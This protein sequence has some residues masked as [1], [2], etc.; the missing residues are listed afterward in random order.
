MCFSEPV[1][2]V[3][4]FIRCVLCCPCSHSH[5]MYGLLSESVYDFIDILIYFHL[6]HQFIIYVTR[7]P[8]YSL[9]AKIKTTIPLKV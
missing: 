1:V 9:T 5:L 3:C 6:I 7:G 2:F 8:G 4:N